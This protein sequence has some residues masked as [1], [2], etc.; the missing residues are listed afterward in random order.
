M[1]APVGLV[2]ASIR[3]LVALAWNIV[4][5]AKTLAISEF[6]DLK[7]GE[8][9]SDQ[10][11]ASRLPAWPTAQTYAATAATSRGERGAPPN[12]GMTP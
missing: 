6:L 10:W 9:A 8:K 11:E 4:E 2:G 3:F 7:T 5:H 12:G 1:A